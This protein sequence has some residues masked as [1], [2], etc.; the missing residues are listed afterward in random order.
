[1]NHPFTIVSSD[2]ITHDDLIAL[3]QQAGAT[4]TPDQVYAGRLAYENIY[5][6]VFMGD[7]SEETEEQLAQKEEF[8]GAPPRTFLIL[9]ASLK[10]TS[11]SY[12]LVYDFTY[13]CTQKYRCLLDNNMGDLITAE[14][15]KDVYEQRFFDH[16]VPP[17]PLSH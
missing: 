17:L 15:V 16:R 9:N 2:E 6:W 8:L 14:D 10:D 13:L 3:L 5:V 4:L 11:I 12:Q 7:A 1:M